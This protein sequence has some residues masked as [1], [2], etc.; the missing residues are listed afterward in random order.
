MDVFNSQHVMH[1]AM[2][3]NSHRKFYNEL[4]FDDTRDWNGKVYSF[5]CMY[6]FVAYK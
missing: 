5:G 1:F 2:S 3:S 4:S 6:N